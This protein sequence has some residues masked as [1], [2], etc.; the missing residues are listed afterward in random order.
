MSVANKTGPY[1]FPEGHAFLQGDPSLPPLPASL[2]P[3]SDPKKTNAS[4]P[5]SLSASAQ[6]AADKAAAQ[7]DK[8]HIPGDFSN[9]Y[10]TESTYA[11]MRSHPQKVERL[12]DQARALAQEVAE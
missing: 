11:L 8:I 10:P 9:L 5:G 1:L 12:A 6:P 4:A 2:F 7:A 3:R